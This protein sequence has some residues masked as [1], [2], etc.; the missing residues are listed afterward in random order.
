MTVEH[1]KP[2]PGVTWEGQ[3]LYGILTIRLKNT[4]GEALRIVRG[5][6]DCDFAID[7]RDSSGNSPKRT[8]LGERL[9]PKSEEERDVCPVVSVAIFEL[10]P[11]KEFTERWYIDRLFQLEPGKPYSVKLTWAKGMP[12]KTP[13]GKPL[14]QLSRTLTIK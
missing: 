11:G 7:L 4:S 14:R 13:S 8:P 9:L 3:N 2:E 6:P 5:N 1:A 10:Q 12:A